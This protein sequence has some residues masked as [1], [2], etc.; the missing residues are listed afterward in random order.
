MT[1]VFTIAP[2]SKTDT[3]YKR[4]AVAWSFVR[5]LIVAIFF[6][7]ATTSF[8]SAQTDESVLYR[9]WFAPSDRLEDWPFGEGRYVQLRRDLF[10]QWTEALKNA[11]ESPESVGTETGGL[12]R[13]VL[14]AKLDGRQLV[15]GRGFF[16]FRAVS[17]FSNHDALRKVNLDSDEP[18]QR[19]L[20][21][22]PW[23]LRVSATELDDGTPV[24]ISYA[25]DGAMRLVLPDRSKHTDRTDHVGENLSDDDISHK[26]NCDR[27]R[28]RWSLRSRS[29][30][31]DELVFDF[32]LPPCKAVE[33]SLD[34]PSSLIPSCP[35]GL[36]FE[37][38]E[39]SSD[40]ESQGNS[41]ESK[42]N[43]LEKTA[44]TNESL[45][46]RWRI[47][48]GKGV[49]STLKI[50]A[51]DKTEAA[52]RKTA[53]R[54]TVVYNISPQ[55]AQVTTKIYFDPNDHRLNDLV[56][57]LESPLRIVDVLYGDQSVPWTR[58][59]TDS[60]DGETRLHVRLS[61]TLK[62]EPRELSVTALM[63]LQEDVDWTL[64]R[65]RIVSNNVFWKET[66]CAFVV[67][68]PLLIRYYS[69]DNG[70]Q[71]APLSSY[72]RSVRE[73]FSFKLFEE[74]AN[75]SINVN[76]HTPRVNLNSGV[77][78][79]WGTNEVGGEMILDCSL[80]EGDRYS[81][82]FPITPNWTIESVKSLNL[83][84]EDIL[85]WDI[86]DTEPG[87]VESTGT[88]QSV[89]N[90]DKRANRSIPTK[91][92]SVQLKRPLLPR[93]NLRFQIFGRFHPG[94]L[95]EFRLADVSP[96]DLPRRKGESHYIALAL[97]V[98]YH[99]QYHSPSPT[100]SEIRDLQDHALLRRFLA[101][102]TGSVFAMDSKNAEI[103]FGVERL[104]PN[105]TGEITGSLLIKEKELVPTFLFRCQPID[106]TV[107]RIHVHFMPRISRN[108]SDAEES[109]KDVAAEKSDLQ[110]LSNDMSK[111]LSWVWSAKSESLQPMLI[112]KLP[113]S[114][115]SELLPS[116]GLGFSPDDLL[117]GETW[118]IRLAVPQTTPFEI[119]AIAS[120]PLS[121]AM[122]VPLAALPLASSQKGEVYIESSKLLQY[123]IVNNRLKSIPIGAT[124]WWRYQE[125]RAAFRYDPQEEIRQALVSPLSLQKMNPD[126]MP[127]AAWVWS[128]RLDTQ[129]ESEG[130]VRNN[131]VLMLE[132]RGKDSLRITL[133]EGLDVEN[134]HAVW[135]DDHRVTWHPER[136]AEAKS[137]EKNDEKSYAA[138]DKS[139]DEALWRENV[140]VVALPE[141]KRFV[142]V[143]LEYSYMDIPLTRQRELHPRY[144]TVDIPVVDGNW[145]SWFP[146]E[147]DISTRYRMQTESG[148]STRNTLGLSRAMSHV[149]SVN[150]FN[151]IS[152]EWWD[153]LLNGKKRRRE[154]EAV[155]QVFFNWI[156]IGL[157]GGTTKRN[158]SNAGHSDSA[159]SEN[160]GTFSYR[161][162]NE[163]CWA[164]LLN[165]EKLLLGM[166]GQTESES[167]AAA[168]RKRRRVRIMVD[169]RAFNVLGL[170]PLSPIS[171]PDIGRTQNLGETIF[172]QEGLVLLVSRS[173]GTDGEQDYVF[174]ITSSLMSALH[175]QFQLE[176]IGRNVR[177][178]RDPKQFESMVADASLAASD[179]LLAPL[180]SSDRLEYPQ[181][182]SAEQWITE[183]PAVSSPWSLASQIIHLASVTPDWT[184]FEIP[185]GADKSLYI[186]HR[187]T[188]AAYSWLAFLLIVL[189]TSRK[190]FSSPIFLIFLMVLFEIL[191]RIVAPCHIGVPS[192]AFLG[193][194]VSLGFCM[195]R[196]RSAQ[197]I[198]TRFRRRFVNR[199]P[200]SGT[201]IAH[202]TSTKNGMTF[203]WHPNNDGI[204]QSLKPNDDISDEEISNE[205]KTCENET[206]KEN[207]EENPSP[208]D[209]S[210]PRNTT[211]FF[212]F[213]VFAFFLFVPTFSATLS[214]QDEKKSHD[215]NTVLENNV[216]E[217]KLAN[218]TSSTPSKHRLKNPYREPHQGSYRDR[219]LMADA[220]RA[221]SKEGGTGTFFAPTVS[222]ELRREP[223]RVFFPIDEVQNIVG[224]AVWIPEEFLRLLYR[225]TRIVTPRP[226]HRWSIDKAEY[227]GSLTYNS[228]TQSFEFSDF[229]AVFEIDLD[230]ENATIVLPFLPL[231]QDGAFWDA[232]PIQPNWLL[233]E[234]SVMSSNTP[235][236]GTSSDA[237]GAGS[238]VF[239][240]ENEK[241]GKHLLELALSPELVRL[242]DTARISLNI[243]KVPNSVLRLKTPIDAP[244]VNV[245]ESLGAVTPNSTGSPV[246]VAEIGPV[247]KIGLSWV[248]E[249]NRSDMTTPEVE[250]Y[251]WLRARP[252]QVDIRA[253]FRYKIEGGKVRSI[254]ILSDPHW[255][256][257]GQFHCEEHPIEQVETIYDTT[258]SD[259]LTTKR[260]EVTRL[261][262]KTPVSG[263]LTLRAGF[264]LRGFNGIGRVR[265]PQ[266]RALHAKIQRNL[267]GISA[268]PLLELDNP[269]VG[270]TS[271]FQAGWNFLPSQTPSS[272]VSAI[273]TISV[274]KTA[275][276]SV[277]GAFS[278]SMPSAMSTN[279]M[280][281]TASTNTSETLR[282]AGLSEERPTVEYD[283]AK[284][285]PS[286]TLGIRTKNNVPR[287][288]SNQS[289]LFDYGDSPVVCVGRFES[290]AEVFQQ[291]FTV[292]P[293]LQIDSIEVRDAGNVLVEIRWGETGK[294]SVRNGQQVRDC[295][296]FFRR[297]LSGR[298][299]VTIQGHMTVETTRTTESAPTVEPA[300]TASRRA[301]P[302]AQRIPVFDFKKVQLEENVLNFF[303]SSMVIADLSID[304]TEWKKS[305]LAPLTPEGFS[306]SFLLGSWT[307]TV[308]P[309]E[310][311]SKKDNVTEMR[312]S[313]QNATKN[314]SKNAV[315][316][317]SRRQPEFVIRPN[318]PIIRG[319]QI[320]TLSRG[321]LGDVWSVA[322]DLIWDITEGELD[323]IRLQWE[324]PYGANISVEPAIPW[325]LEQRSGRSELLLSPKTPL[326]GKQ[327]IR[328]RA[329]LASLDQSV[330]LPRIRIRSDKAEKIETE[331]FVIL[332]RILDGET[333]PWTLS[334]LE[335]VDE[336]TAQRLSTE[337]QKRLGEEISLLISPFA[338]AAEGLLTLSTE[339]G[340]SKNFDDEASA[341]PGIVEAV[342][343]QPVLES[344]R[345]FRRTLGDDFSASIARKSVR[346]FA[347]LYDVNLYVKNNGV[348]F[349][350]ATIDLKSRGR[351][352]FV[353]RMPPEFE[354][355]QIMNSG[356]ASKGTHL[357][358]RRWKIDLWSSDYPQRIGIVFQ[359]NLYS[360]HGEEFSATINRLPFSTSRLAKEKT[361]TL[362]PLPTLEGV[363]IQET[364][365]TLSFETLP[366]E[367]FPT[368][369]ISAVMQKDFKQPESPF[370]KLNVEETVEQLGRH[371]PVAGA[372]AV[373]TAIKLNLVRLDNL[374][375]I[376][377][378]LSTP[379]SGKADELKHWYSHWSDDWFSTIAQIDFQTA[380]FSSVGDSSE[381]R[382]LLAASDRQLETV[383]GRSVGTFID[384]MNVPVTRQALS[385]R[386]L[387]ATEKLGLEDDLNERK[388][389]RFSTNSLVH[390]RG[391][392][393]ED[394]L[395]LFGAGEGSLKELRFVSLP[396]AYRWWERFLD[397]SLLWILLPILLLAMSHRLRLADI[398]VHYPHFWG[399]LTG[400]LLWTFFP[401]GFFGIAT[402]VLTYFSFLKTPWPRHID[403][404]EANDG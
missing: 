50:V 308:S 236:G 274:M 311:G 126:E 289:I 334:Q 137:D 124:E 404:A 240:I 56:L 276:E 41:I 178:V 19:F 314:T 364:L 31:S 283:L 205:N 242:E 233:R 349:G 195:I 37:E 51:D 114:E 160:N 146:P 145:T 108:L 299:T 263:T 333:V 91:R 215:K 237:S 330:S 369:N 392:M 17:T 348:V 52:Q 198:V 326:T 382:L 248:E 65:V 384:S 105:F 380:Q 66:R 163:I 26:K 121:D 387:S 24:S 367:I 5:L 275:V 395:Q 399:V 93:E 161:R 297:A 80:N 313:T 175:R 127:P 100:R 207:A 331:S 185:H 373:A 199:P 389:P 70:V 110:I 13:I 122:Q 377:D 227:H 88:E 173:T 365:W 358:G 318:K 255:Q 244:T 208:E 340:V 27:V 397:R 63:P 321:V 342:I 285:E 49:H 256:L 317:K 282:A 292:D 92:L 170:L 288:K 336:E 155:S 53:V 159:T 251:F 332:P 250:Q 403:R 192:G 36:V 38:T 151:P 381:H 8:V 75:V 2:N 164:D 150:H 232:A 101:T 245:S 357:G 335:V 219:I 69:C 359:G 303:R 102:P 153:G 260:H 229:K 310:S 113:A 135:I 166:L 54:K 97:D 262:F 28:F 61:E 347:S 168:D 267:L 374:V 379:V 210:G 22:E 393:A 370:S 212:T 182:I 60:A 109:L 235:S 149:L 390:W 156:A 252:T 177:Y 270:L 361:T 144:P 363:V 266:I 104:K 223:F 264:V 181:W 133:P 323:S 269:T 204:V 138:H 360:S 249:P 214:A 254:N 111:S 143:S 147:F 243:P 200:L 128:L 296:I 40:V 42:D 32:K 231:Q 279:L 99:L 94:V 30:V 18:K 78:V 84:G 23:G 261:V 33:L 73:V 371:L 325:T 341:S 213:F 287:M 55:G 290:D 3:H 81:L 193:A 201:R 140:V 58:F 21:L 184:A 388:M 295:F 218:K 343:T 59:A 169:R 298:Y 44:G 239:Y 328:I 327:H 118:E 378:S 351:D 225:Q 9:R 277:G 115:L 12:S 183:K 319:E 190:A 98:P 202:S 35:G 103:R 77:Q 316:T 157:R 34:L 386:W 112:R 217:N 353:L 134:V 291:R 90:K 300:R 139:S 179:S 281:A 206:S 309:A 324:E 350:I 226:Q 176:S 136:E 221:S 95:K 372:D 189:V 355:I 48:F 76:Y 46:R 87:G 273:S 354:L 152:S 352:G 230:M 117:Q 302:K 16:T 148:F 322:F 304:E 106:S 211:K 280:S 375:V 71:V 47:L 241:R 362:L 171:M 257:S 119:Q 228:I 301:K 376:L 25:S 86:V 305:E 45:R 125:I 391:R 294:T 14:E 338:A 238:L 79:K 366:R 174:F 116:H 83:P 203:T 293:S 209:L 286:W 67:H 356:I 154:A 196:S 329:D 259:G 247:S 197:E 172:E 132:N 142:S 96:L 43:P 72:D 188:F 64:P 130:V 394:S 7:V 312:S 224:N 396:D 234:E 258:T 345:L 220:P 278:S 4:H 6:F 1:N 158:A 344:T 74:N 82:D 368:L 11:S 39:K 186:V 222:N 141:K 253:K 246:F 191:A 180:A 194:F 315:K 187:N 162:G 57:S 131:A 29:D 265:L 272:T 62:D 339:S 167:G 268:D 89:A 123:H 398:F 129:Y 383:T 346:P 284:T 337:S 307:G 10:E 15:E 320:T 20:S 271:G 306:D 401:L 68:R 107:D 385:V 400:I 402:I 85:S 120:L 165:D 216:L